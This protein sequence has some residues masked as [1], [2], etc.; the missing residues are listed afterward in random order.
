M[1]IRKLNEEFEKLEFGQYYKEEDFKDDVYDIADKLRIVVEYM[2]PADQEIIEK[3][4][5]VID[6]YNG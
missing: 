2:E 4:I 5:E 1:D 6:R 3:A